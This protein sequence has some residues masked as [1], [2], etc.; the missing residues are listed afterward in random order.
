MRF[1]HSS[2]VAC[3]CQNWVCIQIYYY[4]RFTELL[5]AKVY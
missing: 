5:P 2:N 4:I 1:D 3:E